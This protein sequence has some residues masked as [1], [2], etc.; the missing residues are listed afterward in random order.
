MK[1]KI[2]VSGTFHSGERG[3]IKQRVQIKELQKRGAPACRGGVFW[4]I[5]FAH[6]PRGCSLQSFNDPSGLFYLVSPVYESKLSS[7][8][9]QNKKPRFRRCGL[10]YSLRS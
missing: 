8:V 5:R 4:I 10:D 7:P 9:R 2:A 3:G 1:Y 6:D